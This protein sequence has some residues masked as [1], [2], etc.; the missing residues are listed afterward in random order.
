MISK[1]CEHPDKA[2][3]LLSYLI[4]EEG[5]KTVYLG[6][7]GVTYDIVAGKPVLKEEVL[8][9][10]NTNRAEYDRLYGADDTYWMLQNNAIQL[11]WMPPISSRW[12]RWKCGPTHIHSIW[13]NIILICRRIQKVDMRKERLTNCG[14]TLPALC[15]HR[16]KKL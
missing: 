1:N 10:L 12:G 14:E 7:E 11:Q 5:Q 4:S 9:L 8:E 6:V 3:K 15:W 2:I 16:M 13:N